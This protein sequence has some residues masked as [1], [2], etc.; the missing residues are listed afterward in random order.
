LIA[1][2][3]DGRFDNTVLY[4][5]LTALASSFEPYN[6]DNTVMIYLKQHSQALKWEHK[7][8]FRPPKEKERD[9]SNQKNN[10]SPHKREDRSHKRK[11]KPD[12]KSFKSKRI[13]MTD[14][15]SPNPKRIKASGQCMRKSCRQRNTHTNHTHDEC[16]FKESSSK[17]HP[18]LGKAPAKKQCN[19]KT[20][21]SQPIKNAQVPQ[22]KD[23]NGPKCYICDQP[24]HLETRVLAKA[25]SKP[26]H[27][28]RYIRTEASWRYG[29][30]HSST[31]PNK[32]VPANYSNHG[33]TTCVPPAC[34]NYRSS[35]DATRTTSHRHFKA[36]RQRAKH[37]PFHRTARLH[38]KCS[39]VRTSRH[40]ETR[41]H[42]QGTQL[43]SRCWRAERE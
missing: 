39:R 34:K 30:V 17:N 11:D 27:R 26:T 29:R 3:H 32:S 36:H 19:A 14:K 38:S 23:A 6:P 13:K 18:N 5:L 1:T 22:A 24:D 15:A 25:K 16:K 41:T 12:R 9:I 2:L 40:R 42:Q 37:L 43:L 21:A 10:E 8:D 33:E 4:R 28:H 31:K 35:T 20:N 7:F